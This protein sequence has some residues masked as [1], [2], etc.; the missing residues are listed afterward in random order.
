MEVKESAVIPALKL[1]TPEVFRDARG[2]FVE[3]WS[4]RSH[5]FLDPDGQAIE[6]VEDDVS[7]SKRN[8]LRGLHGDGTTWK[9]VH[10]LFGMLFCVVVDL[11]SES[12]SHRKWQGFD[13]DDRA[14]RQL[15]VPAGCATGYV[16]RSDLALL[17][18]KQ[19]HHYDGPERQFTV[20]WDDPAIGVQWPVRDPIMSE[21]DAAAPLQ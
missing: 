3:T 14:R 20:R 18:Y 8:V 19:T 13:L 21:R 10:C 11:R 7:V 12:R 1:I 9:L 16:T 6:F 17:A 5:R 4:T 15:L 2:E